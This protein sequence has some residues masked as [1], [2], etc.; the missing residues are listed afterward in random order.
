MPQNKAEETAEETI[1]VARGVRDENGGR[2]APEEL[3]LRRSLPVPEM[4][5]NTGIHNPHGAPII[6]GQLGGG[7]AS[8]EVIIDT[9]V[10]EYTA[11][12]LRQCHNCENFDREGWLKVKAAAERSLDRDKMRELNGIRAALM[13]TNNV[14]LRERHQDDFGDMDVEHGLNSIGKCHA[15]SSMVMPNSNV[16]DDIFVYPT[17][18]C[19]EGFEGCFVPLKTRQGRKAAASGYDAIMRLAEPSKIRS[20]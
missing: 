20:R 16:P 13:E 6:T 8:S 11:G 19:P 3:P 14:K 12:F 2:L 18:T 15:L 9:S 17:A 4:H 7:I 1:T 5:V 10:A